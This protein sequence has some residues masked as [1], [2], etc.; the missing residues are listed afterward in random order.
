MSHLGPREVY[1]RGSSSSASVTI[2]DNDPGPDIVTI[3]A[4]D[5]DASERGPD[6]GRFTVSRCNAN[7]DLTVT[8]SVSDPATNGTDYESIGNSVTI[9][10]G[11]FSKDIT[12]RPSP[13]SLLEG[14]EPV[15]V[16]LTDNSADYNL[17]QPSTTT[18]A[19][20]DDDCSSGALLRSLRHNADPRG[21]LAGQF[22]TFTA[23]TNPANPPAGHG[24]FYW[25]TQQVLGRD[26][27]TGIIHYGDWTAAQGIRLNNTLTATQFVPWAG[28]YHV[29]LEPC[30]YFNPTRER[31]ATIVFQ[32]N[33]TIS[34]NNVTVIEPT[35]G[36]TTATF[37]VSLSVASTRQVTVRFK[38]MN[39]TATAPG[40][41]SARPLTTLTFPPGVTTQTVTVTVN[42]DNVPERVE[43]FLVSLSEPSSN[44][45]IAVG[46]GIGTIHEKC[47]CPAR[48]QFGAQFAVPM[49]NG[50][51]E[52]WPTPTMSDA[53]RFAL[54]PVIADAP[55]KFTIGQLGTDVGTQFANLYGVSEMLKLY[56]SVVDFGWKV[57]FADLSYFIPD[58]FGNT[59]F[60]GPAYTLDSARQAIRINTVFQVNSLTGTVVRYTTAAER[61]AAVKAALAGTR[62]YTDQN[63]A[64]QD[65]IRADR[66][67]YIQDVIAKIMPLK[68]T[69]LAAAQPGATSEGFDCALRQLAAAYVDG[70][71]MFLKMH[72]GARLR[73]RY[74]RSSRSATRS[75]WFRPA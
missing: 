31:V 24:A 29:K 16:T 5:P 33:P 21:T 37:T 74:R 72:W 62:N 9:P 55:R 15:T 25:H 56:E 44:A 59:Y 2:N 13:D 11:D 75:V 48:V 18:A 42:S 12:V 1:V 71:L 20:H 3:T 28:Q 43:T 19:I 7:S 73:P 38:T 6:T 65:A 68:A 63:R 50:I 66:E 27:A 10:A 4:P 67:A 32:A 34:I 14:D 35:A 64:A 60:A 54:Q 23:R 49:L 39:L 41:Y 47:E 53:E 36:T 61:A 51:P 26:P 57:E 46:Q 58:E 30:W 45:T 17:G 40:D 22:V 69:Y 52:K 70:V 8:F